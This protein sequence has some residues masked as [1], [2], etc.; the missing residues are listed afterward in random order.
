MVGEAGRTPGGGRAA[1]TA[2]NWTVQIFL[3]Q[4]TD[5]T[6]LTAAIGQSAE[7]CSAFLSEQDLQSHFEYRLHGGGLKKQHM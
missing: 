7:T 6:G 4:L 2:L 3:T 5:V 1:G